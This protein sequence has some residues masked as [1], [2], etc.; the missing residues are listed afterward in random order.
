MSDAMPPSTLQRTSGLWLLGV[1]ALLAAC[2][3]KPPPV[4]P[5]RAVRT[6]VVELGTAAQTVEY[7]ADVRART[8]SRLSFRVPGKVQQ[9]LVNL[10]DRV[11]AGQVLMRLDGVD[12]SLA[13]EA[14]PA[15]LRAATTNRDQQAADL[16]R[17]KDL[18]AQGF[19]SG[20]ELERREV[21]LAAAQGQWEQ[22]QAQAK[23]QRNQA[24]Y[25]DLVADAAGL[26]T[27]V[28][29]EPGTVVAAGT[30]VLRLAQDGPR[31]LVFQVPE[32]QVALLKQ[33]L[34][35][36]AARLQARIWGLEQ[37]LPAKVREIAESADPV[38]RTFVVKA[39]I[40]K[41]DGVKLGQTATAVFS[42]GQASGV[43]KVP[44]SA[45]FERQGSPHVWV[46]VPSTMTLRPQ[47]IQVGGADGNMVVVAGGLTAQQ[48]IVIAGTHVLGENQ[49]VRRF[50]AAPAAS[51]AASVAR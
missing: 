9:R 11:K 45:V 5:E 50:G 49:K 23:A 10:G 21:A 14:A 44:M 4:A 18:K 38:T 40:G 24:G 32:H 51:A 30:P 34:Q 41:P 27:S 47:A 17:F 15:A 33:Q 26:I 7:A 36:Q 2:G 8:E 29:A 20:A 13:A 48:E 6:M 1:A 43:L 25:V 12:L 35:S 46:L 19:I 39:D 42:P 16:Q 22:A 37:P 3:P 28:D 31:D